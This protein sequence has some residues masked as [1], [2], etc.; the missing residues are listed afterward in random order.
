[1]IASKNREYV[2]LDLKNLSPISVSVYN[3]I[4]HFKNCIRS[5]AANDLA[6]Y[7][8]LYIFSDAPKPG[9]EDAVSKVREYAKSIT[10]FKKINLIFQNKNNYKKNMK[11]LLELP[12]EVNGKSILMEDDIIVQRSFLRFMNIALNRYEKKDDIYCVSGYITPEN[13]SENSNEVQAYFL[14]VGSGLGIWKRKYFELLEDYNL[15]H[16]GE[17]LKKNFFYL[18]NF[19]FVF[20]FSATALYFQLFDKGIFYHDM[21]SMEYMFRKKKLSV[22]P[23]HTLTL[24]KGYDGS[25]VNCEPFDSIQNE[26][27]LR[28]SDHFDFPTRFNL[29]KAYHKTRKGMNKFKK[30]KNFVRQVSP[31]IMYFWKPPKTIVNLLKKI[32]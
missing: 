19:S 21:V 13:H 11:D 28:Q 3:R 31:L 14:P 1:M 8:I 23:P 32:F 9:D 7:S 30:N 27:F 16:P 10:G 4:D 5:L 24:N 20:G 17:R 18:I 25:G 2:D 12:F 22:I 6:K 15:C 26:K 29:K